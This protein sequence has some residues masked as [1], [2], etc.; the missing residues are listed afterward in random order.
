MSEGK[1]FIGSAKV[2][3]L[4]Y[5][6]KDYEKE[7]D[8]IIKFLE[9]NNIKKESKILELGCGTGNYLSIFSKKGYDIEGM[10]LSEEM[11]KIAGQKCSCKLTQGDIVN[12]DL[13]RKFDVCIVMFDV[14][15]YITKNQDLERGLQNIKNHLNERGLLIFQVWN[16]LGV[17]NERPEGRVKIEENENLRII[18][19]ADPLLKSFENVVDV[20]YTYL[21]L[22]K[23]KNLLDEIHE[24][25]SMRFFF[26][27][28]IEYFLI[29]A[30]F[31]VLHISDFLNKEKP[32]DDS[33]WS[34][35]VV[36]KLK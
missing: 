26:Q 15:S 30:G 32:A 35:F 31:E 18:R 22:D 1:T 23:E 10:D 2:Y 34:M 28:E 25:H 13:E 33:T 24:T 7:V 14:L 19:I 6:E 20:N 36:A 17:L 12:F 5:K 16:G 21:I 8:F 9:E 29:K 3:D 11:L 27:K 4:L